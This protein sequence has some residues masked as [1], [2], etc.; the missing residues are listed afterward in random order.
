[1]SISDTTLKILHGTAGSFHL[2]QAIYAESLVNTI[3]KNNGQFPITNPIG[4]EINYIGSFQLTQ[5]VP[6]FP[7]LSSL[8]HFWALIDFKRYIHFVET[9]YNPIRWIEYSLSASIMTFIIAMLSGIS[10]IKT[11]I[12]LVIANIGMQFIGYS[13]EKD[14]SVTLTTKNK[15]M[16]ETTLREQISG[17]IIL[18]LTFAVIGV[19]F[20]TNVVQDEVP[21]F[22][23]SIIF[24]IFALYLVF[25]ILSFMYTQS[26]NPEKHS[27]LN[28]R[29][30]EVG[31]IVL[32]FISKTF[33]TNM[34]LFGSIQSKP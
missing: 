14:T 20:V 17:F 18:I 16:Y 28:F 21:G 15:A 4:Q 8:N 2:I 27:S 1:M 22:V 19:S 26:G 3:F 6:F 10:D 11:L 25:G 24:I 29:K 7:L 9:G 32:S 13:V 12:G 30:V 23:W 33:L 5:L 34:V 31:Y